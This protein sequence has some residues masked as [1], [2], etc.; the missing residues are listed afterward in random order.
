MS[1]G[2][3]WARPPTRST[4]RAAMLPSP[5]DCL[6]VRPAVQT[7]TRS[8]FTSPG[9]SR[10]TTAEMGKAEKRFRNQRRPALPTVLPSVETNRCG[11]W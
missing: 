5:S 1:E 7:W 11:R 3:H 2:A 4:D 8:P 6:S 10:T 9:A